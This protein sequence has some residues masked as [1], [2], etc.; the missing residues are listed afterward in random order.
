M[1]PRNLRV[2][3]VAFVLVIVVGTV[4]F[5]FVGDLRVGDAAYLTIVTITTLGFAYLA[6][7]LDG[8]EQFWLVL[9]LVA[10]MGAAIYTLTALV[11]Y[12]FETVIGGD[13]R[14]RRKMAKDV[15]RMANHVIVAGYGRVGAT[16]AGA[17]RHNEVDVV[18]VERDPVWAQQAVDDGLHVV[19]GDATRDEVLHEAGIMRAR[20]VIAAVASSSENLVITLSAKAL[21]PDMPVTARAIDAQTEK[22]LNLAG[23]DAVVTP[24]QVGGLRMAALSTQPGLAEFIETVVRDSAFEFRIERFIIGQT[25]QVIGR[26]LSELNLRR[27]SG[28]MIIGVTGEGEPMR[29]NPDPT[30]PFKP[31]DA[32]FGIGTEH[33]LERLRSLLEG[34]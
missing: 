2:G 12:G 17:L 8:R 25:S 33:Q 16:A 18:V 13:H 26:S 22:K 1:L 14:K 32:A 3:L 24:E 27:D 20:S 31:G 30:Q 19:E 7:P 6:E 4:G 9:V 10:G 23:A 34:S 21:R 11:E 15:R 28:A 29:V 5:M